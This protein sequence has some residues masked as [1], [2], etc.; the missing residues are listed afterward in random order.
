VES[1]RLDETVYRPR[2]GG[3]QDASGKRRPKLLT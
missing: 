3:G 1:S 2:G